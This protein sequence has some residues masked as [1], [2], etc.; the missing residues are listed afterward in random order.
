ME[1]VENCFAL[2]PGWVT[3]L[4]YLPIVE[5]GK[6]PS[7]G[8]S[9]LGVFISQ[10]VRANCHCTGMCQPCVGCVGDGFVGSQKIF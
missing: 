7:W 9:Q 5:C 2:L 4:F 10:P 6:E 3:I 1:N 8:A